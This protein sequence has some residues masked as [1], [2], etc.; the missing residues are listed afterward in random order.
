[1]HEKPKNVVTGPWSGSEAQA[2]EPVFSLANPVNREAL[3]SALERVKNSLPV[4]VLVRLS[5]NDVRE[6]DQAVAAVATMTDQEL[7]SLLHEPAV[8]WSK[9]VE[10][11]YYAVKEAKKRLDASVDGE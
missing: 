2:A 10:T 6:L 4:D 9:D 7:L 5:E 1:M 8:D 11:Y 3:H